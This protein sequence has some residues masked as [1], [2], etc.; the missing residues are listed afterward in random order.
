MS[1]LEIERLSVTLATPAGPARVVR[2]LFFALERG[3]SLGIVGESGSGKSM[4]ALAL[5]G[6][7][8]PG[9]EVSGRAAF[10]GEDLLTLG[11]ARLCALR[12]TRLAMVFQEP[13]TSLNPVQRIGDQ[14]AEGL[15]LHRG[16]GRRAALAEALRL[17]DRV[18]ILEA[19]AR[20]S[21]YPHELSGGQRQRVM[22]AIA[23]AC[24]PD[25]L[26]AD[27]PTSALDVTV[28][29]QILELLGGLIADF[30]MALILISHDLAVVGQMAERVLVMYAGQ[31]VEE[32]P[33][34]SLFARRAHPYTQGLFGALPDRGARK[35]K[36]LAAIPGVVP[37]PFEL[38][39]GCSFHGRCPRGREV[40]RAA[41]AW[42]EVAGGHRAR[43][44]FPGAS[45]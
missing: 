40:C 39:P 4:T 8:P 16:L 2:E 11:E 42:V 18:G 36:R 26:I 37:T 34:A 6:L 9:A 15:V 29:A 13:M 19:R 21:A 24:R 1:L 35:G 33:V 44:F 7:L 12:G 5:I 20:L 23:L 41:P 45:P 31:A 3:A 17:L 22:I 14:V 30:G 28:Q 32:G 25:L 38:P 10:D 43:C 27:E